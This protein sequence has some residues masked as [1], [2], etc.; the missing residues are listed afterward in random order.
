MT[1]SL[2]TMVASAIV[3]TMI[4]PVAADKPPMK[5]NKAIA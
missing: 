3:S 5:A 2:E 4:M 1:R